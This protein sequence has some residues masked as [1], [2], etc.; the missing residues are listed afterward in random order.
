MQ[1]GVDLILVAV[2][3]GVIYEVLN[4]VLDWRGR[5]PQSGAHCLSGITAFRVA[6]KKPRSQK[7]RGFTLR[8]P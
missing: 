8:V 2:A 4:G 1:A 6:N 5:A 3:T 7:L